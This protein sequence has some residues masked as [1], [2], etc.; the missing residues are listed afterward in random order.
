VPVEEKSYQASQKFSTHDWILLHNVVL[1]IDCCL[2]S[3]R[4][5]SFSLFST[6]MIVSL[7]MFVFYHMY[8]KILLIFSSA[9][10]TLVLIMFSV[11]SAISKESCESKSFRC[12]M[13][14]ILL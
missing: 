9:L 13:A 5:P 8:H 2:C 3:S 14:V 10:V 6:G 12:D 11:E 1:T 4:L 7:L